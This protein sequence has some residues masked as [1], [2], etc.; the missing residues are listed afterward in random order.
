LQCFS[1]PLAE[2]REKPLEKK[3]EKGEI[4]KGKGKEK[5]KQGRDEGWGE[6]AKWLKGVDAPDRN[7][8]YVRFITV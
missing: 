8:M 1:D 7:A 4:E 2:F 3:Q 5:R 6:L